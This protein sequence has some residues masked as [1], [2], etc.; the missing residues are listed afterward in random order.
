MAADTRHGVANSRAQE[1]MLK[2]G[3]NQYNTEIWD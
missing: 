3:D 1:N 2:I